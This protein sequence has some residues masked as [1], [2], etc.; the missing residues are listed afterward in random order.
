MLADERRAPRRRPW[1]HGRAESRARRAPSAAHAASSRSS[2]T[3]RIFFMIGLPAWCAVRFPAAFAGNLRGRACGGVDAPR[4]PQPASISVW[5]SLATCPTQVRVGALRGV[6]RARRGR[7]ARDRRPPA[8]PACGAD[9]RE[10]SLERVRRRP[11]RLVVALPERALDLPERPRRVGAKQLDDVLQQLAVAARV[12]E[13]RPFVEDDRRRRSGRSTTGGSGT[14]PASEFLDGRDQPIDVDRLREV[15]V[16]AGLQAALAVA[17]HR[18]RG[19]RDDRHVRAGR[20]LALADGRR[21]LEAAHDRH[22]HVH[23]D[24]VERRSWRLPR[25]RRPSGRCPRSRTACPR[26]VSRVVTSLRLTG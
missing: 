3:T 16:H 26:F 1:R 24:D 8:A 14:E 11:E 23:D 17:L 13:R 19:Q 7:S 9:R 4:R 21:G 25:R 18:V 2:S 15:A 6:E 12:Q 22:L 10:R 5:S 20:A